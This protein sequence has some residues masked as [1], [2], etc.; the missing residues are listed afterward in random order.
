MAKFCNH[1]GQVGECG[2][3]LGD[4]NETKC[5]KHIG[6]KDK[7]KRNNIGKYS[8]PSQHQHKTGS[9]QGFTHEKD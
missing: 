8:G 5:K 9:W 7:P 4:S 1:Q 6:K 3:Y 2:M